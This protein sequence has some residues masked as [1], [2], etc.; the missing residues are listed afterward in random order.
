MNIIMRLVTNSYGR[1]ELFFRAVPG[2][3]KMWL[4]IILARSR[5]G[6]KLHFYP[7]H[8]STVTTTTHLHSF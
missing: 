7:F 6:Q 5:N 8:T 3:I 4:S 2:N 1:S